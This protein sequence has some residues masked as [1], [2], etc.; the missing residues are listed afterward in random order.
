MNNVS[1]YIMY[2]SKY[3]SILRDNFFIKKTLDFTFLFNFN[4]DISLAII[5]E[6]TNNFNLNIITINDVSNMHI[7]FSRTFNIFFNY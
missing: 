4:F 6:K 3:L 1:N 2:I 5:I 7:L